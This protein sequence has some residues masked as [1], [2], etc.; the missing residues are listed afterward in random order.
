MI[1][2]PVQASW[3]LKHLVQFGHAPVTPLSPR[4]RKTPQSSG[5]N[6][7][8][9]SLF[10]L[11]PELVRG[12]PLAPLASRPH[13]AGEAEGIAQIRE[14]PKAVS[15]PLPSTPATG[16]RE[17]ATHR[18]QGEDMLEPQASIWGECCPASDTRDPPR[19]QDPASQTSP[20]LSTKPPGRQPT[21]HSGKGASS[22]TSPLAEWGSNPGLPRKQK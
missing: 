1:K 12:W 22:T 8:S 16:I 19:P 14:A 13:M 9:I 7:R 10:S 21:V 15:L 20:G 3:P 11:P 18:G 2:T 5:L 6:K 4:P 17:G